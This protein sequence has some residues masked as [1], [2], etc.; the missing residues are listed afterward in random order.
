MKRITILFVFL[1]AFIVVAYGKTESFGTWIELEFRKDFLERF[2]FSLS[3]EI[4]L[5]DRFNPDRFLLQGQLSFQPVSL[6]ELAASY[7]VETERKTGGNVAASRYAFDAHIKK[8]LSRFEVAFRGRLTN[9]SE[10]KEDDYETFLRPRVKIEYDIKGSKI[11][12]YVSCE[13]FHNAIRKETQKLRY[14][15]GFTRKIGGSHR[16]GG[17]LRLNDYFTE[18]ASIYI[19]GIGYRLRL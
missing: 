13:L 14:D 2:A 3:P 8:D 6:I 10:E 16:I 1:G 12:P 4:R 11:K 19:V 15:V 9:Y 18:K 5:Q 17:Y 7:R